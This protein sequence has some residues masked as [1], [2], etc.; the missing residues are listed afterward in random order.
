MAHRNRWFTYQKWW[1]F[2]WQTVSHNQMVIPENHLQNLQ[3]PHHP[4]P[5][6]RARRAGS[7]VG[8]L[9]QRR[10][11]ISAFQIRICLGLKQQLNL[12][13]ICGCFSQ[14]MRGR[15]DSDCSQMFGGDWMDGKGRF[16]TCWDLQTCK[17]SFWGLFGQK[18]STFD[19][20]PKTLLH[21]NQRRITSLATPSYRSCYCSRYE[22]WSA[23]YYWQ[24]CHNIVIYNTWQSHIPMLDL[25]N[26]NRNANFHCLSKFIISSC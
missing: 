9:E 1:I 21:A 10:L 16:H 20:L 19:L 6:T 17:R 15:K 2:P 8:S 11:L 4:I 22:R 12:A 18:W 7:S 5:T 3:R 14:S 23:T 13:A 24:K 25:Q 26:Q